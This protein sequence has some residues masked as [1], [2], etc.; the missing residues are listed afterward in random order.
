MVSVLVELSDHLLESVSDNLLL[1][2][3]FF[4]DL[5][6]FVSLLFVRLPLVPVLIQEKA[7]ERSIRREIHP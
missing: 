2:P 1:I 6:H 7:D 5:L 4:P 3:G